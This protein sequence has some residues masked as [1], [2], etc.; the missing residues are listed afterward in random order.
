MYHHLL[1]GLDGSEVGR[2]ALARG[3][4][5]ARL[6]SA[7]VTLL[8]AYDDPIPTWADPESLAYRAGLY[9]DLGKLGQQLLDEAA[10]EAQAQGVNATTRLEAR[11]RPADALLKASAGCDLIVVGSHGRR[12]FDRLV[13]GSVAEAVARRATTSVLIVRPAPR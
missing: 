3:L 5:L 7:R 6:T 4:E 8:H 10:A 13:M 12:G 1:I 2:L 11:M 9:Q